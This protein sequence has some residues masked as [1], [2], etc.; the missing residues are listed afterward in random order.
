MPASAFAL[1]WWCSPCV[2]QCLLLL[3]IFPGKH[4]ELDQHYKQETFNTWDRFLIWEPLAISCSPLNEIS[5]YPQSIL[6]LQDSQL[7]STYPHSKS[8]VFNH[9]ILSEF[10]I[11]CHLTHTS[12]FEEIGNWLISSWTNSKWLQQQQKLIMLIKIKKHLAG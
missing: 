3:L 4:G 8:L 2:L 1:A 7:L 6:L 12:I 9:A 11:S 5:S 10:N